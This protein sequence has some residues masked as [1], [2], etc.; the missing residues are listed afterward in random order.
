MTEQPHTEAN[1]SE[2]PETTSRRF[3]FRDGAF[4][5]LAPVP[6]ARQRLLVADSFLVDEGRARAVDLH[7][8]RF[9][10]SALASGYTDRVVL[11]AFW[12]AA[13]EAI[14]PI[15]RWFPRIEL[16]AT[17]S[18]DEGGANRRPGG[19]SGGQADGP[20]DGQ[21]GDGQPG[22]PPGGGQRDGQPGSRPAGSQ[23]RH[24]LS[25]LMRIAPEPSGTVV[26]ETHGGEDPRSIPSVKG[27]DL[28]R[29]TTLRDTARTRGVDDL[30]ILAGDGAII[31]GTTTAIL[32]WRG[33]ELRVP[34]ILVMR[35]SL[36][37]RGESWRNMRCLDRTDWLR[38]LSLSGSVPFRRRRHRPA[39]K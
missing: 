28:E 10:G 26:L 17:A 34:A 23:R 18:G 31:D 35:D 30:V 32:W 20:P 25:L 39:F 4:Q 21:R 27:P 6:D 9:V 22:R 24:E 5:P 1:T 11:D 14:P 29:L 36:G 2:P 13:L 33:A 8:D 15:H 37:A 19:P 3:V 38:R 7:H 12:A 16:S